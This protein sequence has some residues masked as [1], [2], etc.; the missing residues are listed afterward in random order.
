[1]KFWSE[2][3]C[4][5]TSSRICVLRQ[6]ITGSSFIERWLTS[7]TQTFAKNFSRQK[8]YYSCC[9]VCFDSNFF[10]PKKAGDKEWRNAKLVGNDRKGQI[11]K[12][13][14]RQIILEA[15]CCKPFFCGLSFLP[16]DSFIAM[17][18]VF[19][20]NN[21]NIFIFSALLCRKD[22]VY[23]LKIKIALCIGNPTA[24]RS[25]LRSCPLPIIP[26][27]PSR[28]EGVIFF[29]LSPRPPS[30]KNAWSQVK[31]GPASLHISI[32]LN[33]KRMVVFK[34]KDALSILVYGRFYTK[35]ALSVWTNLCKHL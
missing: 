15:F 1:M 18:E 34:L 21:W 32:T 9:S 7:F 27:C 3:I 19:F 10:L 14:D 20:N 30:K 13:S 31:L 29:C 11:V 4:W 8:G 5:K 22:A 23:F 2:Q 28:E 35:D 24:T 6:Y 26:L 17:N 16:E 25:S 12:R 33:Q